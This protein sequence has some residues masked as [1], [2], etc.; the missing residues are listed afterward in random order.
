[1]NRK[2]LK[3]LMVPKDY[4]KYP[5][6]G[7]NRRPKGHKTFHQIRLHEYQHY[8]YAGTCCNA[9]GHLGHLF[10][11]KRGLKGDKREHYRNTY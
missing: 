10:K 2:E 1:M 9:Y 6:F 3:E 7:Q 4:E 11:L 5:Y 8:V